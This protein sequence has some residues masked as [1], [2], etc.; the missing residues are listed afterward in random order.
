[1]GNERK[2]PVVS[3]A[4]LRGWRQTQLRR[5][6]TSIPSFSSG[7]VMIRLG[8]VGKRS[9]NH[10][11]IAKHASNLESDSG[12]SKCWMNKSLSSVNKLRA[13]P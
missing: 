12:K 4:N 1:M 9:A 8:A 2:L 11:L 13:E 5:R 7:P 10:V 3:S 6:N